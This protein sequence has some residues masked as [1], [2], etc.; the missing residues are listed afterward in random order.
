METYTEDYVKFFLHRNG[1]V[2]FDNIAN[3][4]RKIFSDPRLSAIISELQD[5]PCYAIT[6]HKNAGHPLHKLSFIAELGF[7]KGDPGIPAITN[8]ILSHQSPEGPFQVLINIPKHFGGTGEPAMSW[9]LCDAP[10]LTYSLIKL[11]NNDITP[12]IRKAVVHIAGLVS[13]KGWHCIAAPEL[14]KFR[15]PGRKEDP[16]PYA[17][18]LSLKLLS[19]TGASEYRQA[20]ESGIQTLFDCWERRKEIRPYLFGMGR[21]FS[22]LKLPFVWYDIL[23]VTDTLSRYRET[24]NE[25]Q[26]REMLNII[27]DKQGDGGYIP[28]SIYLK[29]RDWDFG[30]K[31][32]PSQFMNAVILR[33]ERRLRDYPEK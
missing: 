3:I 18:M 6:N 19:L 5:W 15:G 27:L 17:T 29:T 2:K 12:P 20:K 14:G 22:K 21:D 28:E 16:C 9:V 1:I 30:Q 25:P 11:N 8:K 24:H 10:L 31:K 32:V 23:N 7:R 4:E 13:A 26:F 33:I